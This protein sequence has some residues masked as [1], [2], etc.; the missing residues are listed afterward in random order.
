VLEGVVEVSVR[1][2]AVRRTADAF[3]RMR[4]LIDLLADAPGANERTNPKGR[5]LA[6]ELQRV[7]ATT[8]R[9]LTA[10]VEQTDR[11]LRQ[12][13]A[14]V[15]RLRLLPASLIFPSLERTARDAALSLGKRV[16]FESRGGDVRLDSQVLATVQPALVQAVRNALAHG[17]ELERERTSAGKPPA[18]TV[19]IEVRRQASW[20][21]FACRDDGRG[22]DVAAVR[23]AAARKG[24]V[25]DGEDASTTGEVLRVLLEGGLTT[26]LE[27]TEVA[28]RGIGLDVV[29]DAASRLGGRLAMRTTP[30]QGTTLELE[31]PLSLSAV[32]ALIVESAGQTA[33]LPL[34]SVRRSV[35]LAAG[36]V[37]RAA[38]GESLVF[39]GKMIPFAPLSRALGR[40]PGSARPSPLA[41]VIE[42]GGVLVATGVDRLLGAQSVVVR[43]LPPL[44]LVDPVVGG[45]S[46]DDQGNPQVVLDAA[47]LVAATQR[48]PAPPAE[49]PAPRPAILVIDDSLTTRMLEQSILEAAGYQV[50][51]AVSAEDGLEKARQRPHA[52]FLVD[53]EMPG[54]DGFTFVATTRADPELSRTPA[55]LVTSRNAPDD[56]RRGEEAG[57]RGYIVKSEFDQSDLLERIRNLVEERA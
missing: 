41:V 7:V 18:G 43:A 6:E 16:R 31:V 44:A 48:A 23:R 27:V 15:E 55:I 5:S 50:E 45:A 17:I 11:E 2:G 33:A 36:D 46:F 35:R 57:A 9:D 54:M 49:T 51:V 12:V 30:Q 32:E 21:V 28:G 25:P 52:L 47:A 38:Q 19:S 53:V 22:V 13:R 24:L 4:G 10:G 40:D 1:L 34:E 20:V 8:E 3:A 26:S 42:S 56:R 14:S 39:D 29:R 37:V